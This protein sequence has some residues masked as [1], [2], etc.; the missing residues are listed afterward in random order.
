MDYLIST[1]DLPDKTA[2]NFCPQI[3]WKTL[4]SESRIRPLGGRSI[5]ADVHRA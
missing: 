5:I 1:K 4:C 3:G 2:S